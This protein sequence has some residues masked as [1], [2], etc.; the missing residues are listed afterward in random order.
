MQGFDGLMDEKSSPLFPVGGRGGAVVTNDYA[1]VICNHGP[2]GAG[3]IAGLK[4]HVLSSALSPQCHGHTCE[5]L[6]M[7]MREIWFS[8]QGD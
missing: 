4:F 8:F 3:D 5:P 7:D 1:P 2:Y 6:L